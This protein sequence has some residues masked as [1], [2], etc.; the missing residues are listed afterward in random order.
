MH[1]C[2][3]ACNADASRGPQR[4]RGSEPRRRTPQA[5][6]SSRAT[7]TSPRA[8]SPRAFFGVACCSRVHGGGRERPARAAA[9]AHR[10]AVGVG[11]DAPLRGGAPRL[12]APRLRVVVSGAASSTRRASSTQP[13]AT[14]ARARRAAELTRTPRRLRRARAGYAYQ[15]PALCM[16]TGGAGRL[17]C[18]APRTVHTGYAYRPRPHT[19][20]TAYR[21]PVSYVPRTVAPQATSRRAS[22]RWVGRWRCPRRWPSRCARRCRSPPACLVRVRVRVGV[23]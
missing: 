17:A 15:P 1:A 7:S 9:A 23:S 14:V 5:P 3:H 22:R 6:G 8:L 16:R 12:R 18:R 19:V 4:P 11:G 13:A 10:L 2:M 20:R 21:V